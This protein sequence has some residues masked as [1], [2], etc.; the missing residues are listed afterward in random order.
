MHTIQMA[1]EE[2]SEEEESSGGPFPDLA[3]WN[4]HDALGL[5]WARQ[6]REPALQQSR[7]Q[8]IPVPP[9]PNM[10][11]PRT[12]GYPAFE[13]RFHELEKAGITDG[14]GVWPRERAQGGSV[15]PG[16]DSKAPAGS[17]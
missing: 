3:P 2:G 16:S 13:L 5:L 11:P 12:I 1:L 9:K 4:S 15:A 8:N 7:P 6:A 10:D 14:K 17:L